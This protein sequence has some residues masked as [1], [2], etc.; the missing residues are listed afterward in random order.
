MQSKVLE[1]KKISD[2]KFNQR[3]IITNFPQGQSE[4]L[5]R[6]LC[7]CFGKVSKVELVLEQGKFAGTANVDFES[8]FEAKQAFSSMM[9]L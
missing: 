3:L 1:T 7:T 8:E 2:V 4:E 5:I 6:D 9:G